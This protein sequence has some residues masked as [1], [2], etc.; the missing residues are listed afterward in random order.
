MSIFSGSREG[1]NSM[2]SFFGRF[3]WFIGVLLLTMV[4]GGLFLIYWQLTHAQRQTLLLMDIRYDLEII[5]G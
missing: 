5:G 1:N 2:D 4:T 3:T